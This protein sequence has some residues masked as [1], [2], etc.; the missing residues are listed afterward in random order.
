MLGMSG[1]LCDEAASQNG[2]QKQRS[3][4]SSSD[5]ARIVDDEGRRSDAAA[6]AWSTESPRGST[7]NLPPPTA[8]K[9]PL[10]PTPAKVC[11][12]DGAPPNAELQLLQFC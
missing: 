1:P 6:A 7:R 11:N 12:P 4:S 8:V 5:T 2:S 10:P 3:S 9:H